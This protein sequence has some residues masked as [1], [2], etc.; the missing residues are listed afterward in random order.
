MCSASIVVTTATVGVSLR[1]EPSD[2]SASATRYSP[3][4]SRA[5][6]PR[7]STRPPTTMVGSKRASDSTAPTID[8][9]VVLPCVPATATPIF[10]RM[11]SASISARGMVGIPR[12][13]AAPSSTLSRAI[14][15][16]YT[17]TWAPSTFDASWPM[18]TLAPAV[19]RRS[20]AS[21]RF[22]SDPVTT[23]PSVSRISAIPDI[24]LP[25]MPTKWTCWK[26]LRTDAHH[27]LRYGAALGPRLADSAAT[28]AVLR[29]IEQDPRRQH[30][31]EQRRAAERDERQRQ[32]L[33]GQESRDGAQVDERLDGEEH[34]DPQGEV[35]AERVGR[36]QAHAPAAPHEHGQ[37][38]D[39]G[40]GA[41]EA[42]LFADDRED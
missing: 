36:A 20:I 30:R 5:F 32:A 28:P 39:D 31:H 18:K 24:P 33:G 4:P 2:S 34:R 35:R 23:W 21:L 13:R 42:E 9:V 3:A 8:V 14:A 19:S 16:E 7:L 1:K 37:Q 17:T 29:D 40:D 38:P 10:M 25:P 41:H 11:S 27:A 22:S 15:E 26:R 6:A 12:C